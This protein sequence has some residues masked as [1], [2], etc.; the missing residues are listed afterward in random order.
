MTLRAATDNFAEPR[1]A[2]VAQ[3]QVTVIA[4]D[5]SEQ[6]FDHE[7]NT[8]TGARNLSGKYES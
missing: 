8:P 2:V 6:L 4:A 3:I 5:S 1:A 7:A